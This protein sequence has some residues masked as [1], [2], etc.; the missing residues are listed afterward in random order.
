MLFT[1]Q[2]PKISN[3]LGM[4]CEEPTH[5]KRPWSWERLMAGEKRATED[6]MVGWHHWLSRHEFKQI[7]EDSE[8]EGSLVCCSPWESQKVG[9]DWATKHTHTSWYQFSLPLEGLFYYDQ[10]KE[11]PPGG[12]EFQIRPPPPSKSLWACE[13]TNILNEKLNHR[14]GAHLFVL[15]I[16]DVLSGERLTH[17]GRVSGP[18]SSREI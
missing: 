15:E 13:Q 7:P 2:Y 14:R 1:H 9:R 16:D 12:A 17:P 6:E 8:G 18:D 5:W 3:T 4:W 10:E 11:G